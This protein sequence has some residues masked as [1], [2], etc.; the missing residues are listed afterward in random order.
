MNFKDLYNKYKILAF[1]IYA[2]L[3]SL[4]LMILNTFWVELILALPLMVLGGFIL[5]DIFPRR[6]DLHLSGIQVGGKGEVQISQW[7]FVRAVR[8]ACKEVTEIKYSSCVVSEGSD[9]LEIKLSI[10]VVNSQLLEIS[11]VTRELVK[12]FVEG[13]LN[14]K[15]GKV[16]IVVVNTAYELGVKKLGNEEEK[17]EAK[18][19][20]KQ[21]V[22]S[23]DS[24]SYLLKYGSGEKVF[25]IPTD[26]VE[27]ETE[28]EEKEE[29]NIDEEKPAEKQE[30]KEE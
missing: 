17:E 27:K 20:A 23:E 3:L 11:E 9:G 1:V 29:D 7:A 16:D 4:L 24:P 21:A 14:V 22:Y 18:P 25:K 28:S 12:E 15:V 10:K 8:R 6:G 5:Y 26:Y 19:A 30:G 13:E 2:L